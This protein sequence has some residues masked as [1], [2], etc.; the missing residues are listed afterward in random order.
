MDNDFRRN[1]TELR[2]EME[3]LVASCGTN[4]GLNIKTAEEVCSFVKEKGIDSIRVWFVDLL[5]S[6]KSFSIT[7]AELLGA[8]NEGMG[9]DGSS[10]EGY[11]RINE[12]DMVAFPVPETAQ[13]IP[14]KIGGSK[15]LRMFAKIKTPAGEV[16]ERDPRNALKKTLAKLSRYNASHMNVGPEA[17]F[18][19][20]KTQI[21]V[22]HLTKQD[23]LI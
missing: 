21:V 3:E 15:C 16:Y 4:Q 23:T 9:F 13:L 2:D 7:P 6:L 19:T 20:L 1:L 8:L 5:G 12:S 22:K 18:F 11:A 14:F 17:D 10:V